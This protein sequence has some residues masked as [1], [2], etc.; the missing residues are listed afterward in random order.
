MD[1][2]TLAQVR[3][4]LQARR[5]ELTE[6]I[7][8]MATEIQ[9]IGDDQGDEGSAGNHMGDD[10]SNVSEA[11]RLSTLSADMQDVLSQTESALERLDAGT[12]GLCQRC[13]QPIAAER[14]EAFPFVTY[15]IQCQAIVERERALRLGY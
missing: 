5:A 9:W 1:A 14:L 4:R 15:C 6:E 12:Y 3:Q 11:E 7:A 13:G 2:A 10:G 8:R